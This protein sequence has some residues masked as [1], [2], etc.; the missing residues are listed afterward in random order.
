MESSKKNNKYL[1][2]WTSRRTISWKKSIRGSK[3]V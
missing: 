1:I 2:S 3:T